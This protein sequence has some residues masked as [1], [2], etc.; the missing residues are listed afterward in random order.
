MGVTVAG[1]SSKGQS[2]KE[3]QNRLE[4]VHLQ[5]HLAARCLTCI[6]MKTMLTTLC[7]VAFPCS[8]LERSFAIVVVL[9]TQR[10]SQEHVIE[11]DALHI[12]FTQANSG[13][14]DGIMYTCGHEQEEV[15]TVVSFSWLVVA[16]LCKKSSNAHQ[17][18][19][20]RC[21]YE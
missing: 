5:H 12:F 4:L 2:T 9:L 13:T 11:T 8:L 18:R 19:Q 1:K 15:V 21:N 10:P 16:V 3:W 6:G 7:V 20:L 14:L 17:L